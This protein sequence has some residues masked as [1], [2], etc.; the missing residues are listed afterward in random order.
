M[1]KSYY[2]AANSERGFVSLFPEIFNEKSLDRLYIIKAGPGTGKSTLMKNIL[3]EAQTRGIF[4]EAYY[5]S[6]DT[7]SLDG[8]LIPSLRAAIIDGTAPHT[9]DPRY[10][11]AC[12][13]VLDLGKHLD[14]DILRDRRDD[15]VALTDKCS[16]CYA[17]AKR[18]LS[19]AGNLKRAYLSLARETFDEG[20]ARRAASRMLLP[21]APRALGSV[22]EKYIS[23]LGTRGRE[24]INVAAEY[25]NI[26]CVSGTYGAPQLFMNIL[27][28]KAHER[29]FDMI[30]FPDVLLRDMS[31]GI[32]IAENDTLYIIDDGG[33]NTV[34]AM[35]FVDKEKISLVRQKMRFLD[36]CISSLADGALDSLSAMGRTHDALEEMYISAMDFSLNDAAEKKIINEIFAQR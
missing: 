1:F 21:L 27:Y 12:A 15:I 29:G 6:A 18:F 16:A 4:A 7:R 3:K 28:E 30:R 20:K 31:E 26:V 9:A 36:K 8:V 13:T 17:L 25:E 22:K 2:A 35:R 14:I 11:G 33:K 10:V 23:A 24:R 19:S 5:C 34:N 32:Y